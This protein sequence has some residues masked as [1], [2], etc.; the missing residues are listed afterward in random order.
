MP[1][2]DPA[3]AGA[4]PPRSWTGWKLDDVGG[5]TV[6]RVAGVMV[7]AA[8]AEAAWLVVK[9]GRFGGRAAV[10]AAD[11][12]GA[13]GRVWVPYEA[14]LIKSAKLPDVGELTREQELEL[15]SHFGIPDGM[16]RAAQVGP[17]TSAAVT[18]RSGG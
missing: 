12:V 16:G 18:A 3:R 9:V 15:C 13:Q 14:E 8:A 7:D 6:G 2:E 10:P 17:R 1:A 4:T 5:S 11:A